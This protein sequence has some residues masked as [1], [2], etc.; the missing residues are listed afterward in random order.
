MMYRS[1]VRYLPP[2]AV[3]HHASTSSRPEAGTAD[4]A[5]EDEQGKGRKIRRSRERMRPIEKEPA[6]RARWSMKRGIIPLPL[7]RL[8]LQTYIRP[9]ICAVICIASTLI[10]GDGVDYRAVIEFLRRHYCKG[11]FP[12]YIIVIR[13]R[14]TQLQLWTNLTA[15]EQLCRADQA[16]N[17]CDRMFLRV[18]VWKHLL[19][20]IHCRSEVP[21]V[22]RVDW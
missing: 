7:I 3:Y 5:L 18:L 10:M 1:S 4:D 12:V 16:W 8:G 13:G 20:Y 14:T 6:S 21:K 17:V 19:I 15:V 9:L 22:T 11:W 2:N